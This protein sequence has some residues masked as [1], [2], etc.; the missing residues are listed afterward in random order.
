[1]KPE[2]RENWMIRTDGSHGLG[3]GHVKRCLAIADELARRGHASVF[4]FR[5][6]ED[7]VLDLM[8]A[9]GH[10]AERL[11]PDVK[12]ENEPEALDR[13]GLADFDGILLDI[14]HPETFKEVDALPGLFAGLRR[15]F[16]AV[17]VLD[18]IAA[19]C[20]ADRFELPVDLVV[21][22]Y[23]GT[24]ACTLRTKGA[25]ICLGPAYFVLDRSYAHCIGKRR[26]IADDA[27]RLLITSGGSDPN[28]LCLKAVLALDDIDDRA[29][30]LRVVIGPAFSARSTTDLD[31]AAERSRHRVALVDRPTSLVQHMAWCDMAIAASGLT[32]YELAATGTPAVIIPIDDEAEAFNRP[33]EGLGTAR[34]LGA[35]ERLDTARI[36]RAVVAM[37]DDTATR[38]TMSRAGKAVLDGRGTDRLV[39]CLTGL[40]QKDRGGAGPL[41]HE[42]V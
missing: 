15:R 37:L 35:L 18:N 31:R 4:V 41:R 19:F 32:K 24:E 9:S 33:F 42:F 28:G 8:R 25:R 17:A 39:D 27:R 38:E 29:L 40:V 10:R 20:L 6:V 30:A 16:P 2:K 23:A 12:T 22:P 3:L 5:R 11:G 34:H 13:F 1:M 21:I 36:A 26:V 7:A 14:S